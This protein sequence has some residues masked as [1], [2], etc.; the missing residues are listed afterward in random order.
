MTRDGA[1][2][3]RRVVLLGGTS[4]IGLALVVA[5]RLQPGAT[6]VLAGR[7]DERLMAAAETLPAEL[8]VERVCFDAASPETHAALFD[9]LFTEDVD[10]LVAAFGVLPPQ[11]EAEREPMRA[12]D[13]IAVNLTGQVSALLHAARHMRE[14]AHGQL[15]VF[16]SIAAVR[17]RRANYVYGAA[18]AGLDAFASGLADALHGGGVRL[19]LVRPGFVR[20]R[21]TQ[22][23]AAAPFA[24]TPQAVA[25][26]TAKALHGRRLVVWVPSSLGAVSLAMRFMPR[27]VWRRLRF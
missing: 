26:A 2:R 7:D 23:M 21:M 22:G 6:V 1:G 10:L 13:S 12:V 5:L 17:G 8:R 25:A 19:L 15:V 18:K 24:T 20:G 3:P 14:Q 27:S 16:S 11:P 9:R 4:E